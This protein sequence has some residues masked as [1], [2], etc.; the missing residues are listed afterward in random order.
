MEQRSLNQVIKVIKQRR[1]EL[2]YSQSYL[3]GKIDM[4][5]NGYSNIES[6][7]TALTVDRLISLCSALNLSPA[8]LLVGQE[9]RVT[10]MSK[11]FYQSTEPMWMFDPAS[12]RFLEVNEAATHHYGFTHADFMTMTICGH[13]TKRGYPIAEGQGERTSRRH[14]LRTTDQALGP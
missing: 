4:S 9:R 5:Q 6:G 12:L 3:A 7:Q 2:G 11:L 10:D 14:Y 1:N 13:Q 8:H